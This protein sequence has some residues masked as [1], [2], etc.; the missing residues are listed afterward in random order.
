MEWGAYGGGWRAPAPRREEGPPAGAP[1][2]SSARLPASWRRRRRGVGGADAED[3]VWWRIGEAS[4]SAFFRL[5]KVPPRFR[6]GVTCAAPAAAGSRSGTTPR[7]PHRAKAGGPER[8]AV[9]P[10]APRA[11]RQLL[12]PSHAPNACAVRPA[13][14]TVCRPSARTPRVTPGVRTLASTH[15]PWSLAADYIYYI[16]KYICKVS[17][18]VL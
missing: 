10:A 9:W 4:A 5:K 3:V 18:Q 1:I 8:R 6:V 13:A 14:R 15:E 12:R 7:P 2:R 16:Y 11:K 17:I